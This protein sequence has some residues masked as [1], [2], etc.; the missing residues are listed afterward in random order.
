VTGGKAISSVV[1][2]EIRSFI[3]CIQCSGCA[4]WF[5]QFKFST[6]PLSV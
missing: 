2:T 4:A 1:H 5:K 6:A 3:Y